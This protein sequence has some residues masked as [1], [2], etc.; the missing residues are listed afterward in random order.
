MYQFFS[1]ILRIEIM[2]RMQVFLIEAGKMYQFFSLIL[3]IEIMSRMQVVGFGLFG[4]RPAAPLGDLYT[5]CMHAWMAASCG[6]LVL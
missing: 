1:L 2:C 5:P 3:R 6:A 4:Q